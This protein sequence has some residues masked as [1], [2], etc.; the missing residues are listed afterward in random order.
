MKNYLSERNISYTKRDFRGFVTLLQNYVKNYF[1]DAQYDFSDGSTG[2]M[3]I[4]LM[5]MM[6][7]VLSYYIDESFRELFLDTAT[8]PK[9]IVNLANT[10]GYRIGGASPS[11]V[12]LTLSFTVPK[13]T[14]PSS[15]PYFSKFGTFFVAD[16]EHRTVFTPINDIDMRRGAT[17]KNIDDNNVEVSKSFYAYSGY[18][19]TFKYDVGAPKEYLDI[20]ISDKNIVGVESIVDSDN[21]MWYEVAYLAQET[22]FVGEPNLLLGPPDEIIM[23]V[24]GPGKFRKFITRFDENGNLHIIFGP[25]VPV[26][27]DNGGNLVINKTMGEAPADTVLT[28]RYRVCGGIND[29]V[30]ANTVKIIGNLE[31]QNNDVNNTSWRDTISVTNTEPAV[32]GSSG[33]DIMS[34]K[35]KIKA[36]FATQFRAVTV[37]DIKSMVLSMPSKFGKVAKV[38]VTLIKTPKPN[39]NIREGDEQSQ[40]N[41][42]IYVLTYDEDK[43]FALCNNIIKDNISAYLKP[44]VAV[45]YAIF[46]RDPIIINFSVHFTIS[47]FDKY[48]KE[49]VLFNC[50]TQLKEYFSN[51]NMEINQPIDVEQVRSLLLNI[52]GV[53][54]VDDITFNVSQ[55]SNNIAYDMQEKKGFIP[56]P[57]DV[58]SIFQ[59][60]NPDRN[61]IGTAR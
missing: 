7:D 41:I 54:T 56:T 28:I 21:R 32:G 35:E 31:N 47:V 27:Y 50:I 11:Y 13:A 52:D 26:V 15:Y 33:E 58:I 49:E 23:V 12:K 51:D 19:K 16:N 38:F 4:E 24:T 37:D 6:G 61:I 5:A 30:P 17:I 20:T 29:N 36:F 55:D 40:N 9:S 39:R 22:I 48:Y 2:Q 25:G 53:R 10:L 57:R 46:I 60:K 3:F 34:V 14:N 43:N 59:L 45:N 44:Y 42:N 8:D 18:T 1:K